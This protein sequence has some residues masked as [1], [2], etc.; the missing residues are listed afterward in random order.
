MDQPHSQ[1]LSSF[2]D[3]ASYRP[4]NESRHAAAVVTYAVVRRPTPE[5]PPSLTETSDSGSESNDYQLENIPF[6]IDITQ[7]LPLV[8]NS[9]EEDAIQL[10]EMKKT[11]DSIFAPI[12]NCNSV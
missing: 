1:A 6:K 12:R 3:E 2:G 7:P 9:G 8:A 11:C 10:L 5:P 4:M